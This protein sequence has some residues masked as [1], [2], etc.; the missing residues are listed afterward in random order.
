[1]TTTTNATPRTFADLVAKYNHESHDTTTP[2]YAQALTDL[3][4]ATAYAVLKKVISATGNPMLYK[5]RKEMTAD[6]VS[7]DRLA[8]A[9]ERATKTTYTA[10]G[11]RKIEIAD[12]DCY[13]AVADLCR[14]NLGDGLDLVNDA[15][16]AIL[17]QTAKQKERE[18]EQ[19]V[20]L[21]RPFTVRRLN[22]KV[23]IQTADT[24]GGWETKNTTPIQ[25]IFK[26]VRRSIDNARAVQTDP[27]NGY[28]YIEDL[29]SDP[30]SDTTERIYKR[31]NKYADLGGNPTDDLHADYIPGAPRDARPQSTYSADPT[32]VEETDRLVAQMGLTARQMQILS[33]RQ[34]GYG[35]K[36]I[37]TYLGITQRAVA[38]TIEGIQ[39]KAAA[40]G[41]TPTK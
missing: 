40:I 8:Y 38:K 30:E 23:W 5:V 12:R 33:L 24:V 37:A 3:A 17:E 26:A 28:T 21:E 2:T 13:K 1:M 32:I 16:I 31:L 34:S 11:D 18:P 10:D 7:L 39:A 14:Q 4:T 27:R 6:L 36:A 29:A 35:Y 41:L 19:A 25:E 15:I 22:R 9:S 20:D